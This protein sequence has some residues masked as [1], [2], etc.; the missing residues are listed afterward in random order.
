[1]DRRYEEIARNFEH[2][3]ADDNGYLSPDEL[4]GA[5]MMST[6][7]DESSAR[8]FIANFDADGNG[9]IDKTEFTAM[10]TLMFG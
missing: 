8:Q 1:M 2:L 5:I 7:Y 4:V 10:W 9:S 3:D 6:G